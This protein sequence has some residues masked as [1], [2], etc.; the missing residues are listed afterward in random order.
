MK[1][2][3]EQ[4]Y[5]IYLDNYFSGDL[6]EDDKALYKNYNSLN[7]SIKR[8]DINISA[9]KFFI[10]TSSFVLLRELLS[11]A[12]NDSGSFF[13][14]MAGFSALS[15]SNYLYEHFNNQKEAYIHDQISI[16]TKVIRKQLSC[17]NGEKSL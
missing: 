6:D 17:K 16:Y 9:A 5:E 10:G 3:N 2:K 1:D 13:I 15:V 4:G 7:S 11:G 14:G 8:I 12:I